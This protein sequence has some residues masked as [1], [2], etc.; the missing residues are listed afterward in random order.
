MTPD[1]LA[2]FTRLL[3]YSQWANAALVEA[4][5]ECSDAELDRPLEIGPGSGTLRRILSHTCTAEEI[6]LRRWRQEPSVPWPNEAAPVS[7]DDLAHRFAA[8][9]SARRE[10]VTALSPADLAREQTYRDSKGSH[11]RA[12]L[13]DML[14]QGLVHSIHHR[15]QAANALRRLDHPGPDLDFM[16]H[17]RQPA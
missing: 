14:L 11:F 8:V 6:W 1:H 16:Y 15:A 9:A 3:D 10:F 4:A 5:G 12:T 17:V 2:P 7:L 13:S